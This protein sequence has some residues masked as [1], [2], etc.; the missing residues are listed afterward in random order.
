MGASPANAT[1]TD[2]AGMLFDCPS[3][4][5]D[6]QQRSRNWLAKTTD[7][8][9]RL[10]RRAGTRQPLIL[11]GHGVRLRIDRGSLLVKDGFTHYPQARRM[12]RFFPGEWRLPSRIV[13]VDADGGLTLDVLFWLSK[14]NVPLVQIDWRGNV[15]GT[16]GPNAA[17]INPDHVNA[18]L[19]A[20]KNGLALR[21]ATQLVAA[22]ISNSIATLRHALP[23]ET[24]VR[25]A[26]GRMQVELV[27]LRR[28][29]PPSISSLLGVEGK[30]GLAY[31]S[32]WRAFP[33]QWGAP[34]RHPIP[35]DWR[36]IGYRT[37]KLGTDRSRNRNA[38]HPVNAML[39][40]AYGVLE[41]RVR[42][43]VLAAGF[44]PTIGLFHGRYKN[45]Q[46]FVYDLMEPLRPLIDRCIL[47]FI[48]RN[49]FSGSDFVIGPDGACR[50]NPELARAVVRS[51][52]QVDAPLTP[53]ALSFSALRRAV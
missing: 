44:D 52:W 10:N 41:S 35:D 2:R 39:N 7:A 3:D 42:A 38:T 1:P 5:V 26:I 50:L 13:L 37:S 40:Y 30:V 15:T 12:W 23:D 25:A 4:D 14:H 8:P 51:I 28:S 17:A 20:R 48:T 47:E 45:K 46:G 43:Q 24:V 53:I 34:K 16:V 29:P 33:I 18:Q 6:W 9:Q 27:S 36:R 11:S 32:A 22:K 31:F 21:L 49:V 19:A